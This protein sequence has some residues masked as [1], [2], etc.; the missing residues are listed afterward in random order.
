MFE[1]SRKSL[2]ISLPSRGDFHDR[3]RSLIN[4][5]DYIADF[6]RNQLSAISYQFQQENPVVFA[7]S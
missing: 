7:E 6:T 4:I 5:E 2:I 1:N 3:R